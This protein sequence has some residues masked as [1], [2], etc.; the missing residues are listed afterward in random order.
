MNLLHLNPP[1]TI[2]QEQ[3]EENPIEEI[4][5]PDKSTV[6]SALFLPKSQREQLL[7]DKPLPPLKTL[8]F[9]QL[10]T[11]TFGNLNQRSNN[12]LHLHT[13]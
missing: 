11:H 2:Y 12:L 1:V 3:T 4:I 6:N 10:F 8:T 13:P 7:T 5:T 9:L